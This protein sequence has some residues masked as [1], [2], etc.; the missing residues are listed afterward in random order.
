MTDRFIRNVKKS[1]ILKENSVKKIFLT[2]SLGLVVF[3]GTSQPS[4]A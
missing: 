2:G 1:I 3:P 4:E